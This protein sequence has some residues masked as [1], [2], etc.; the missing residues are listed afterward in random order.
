MALIL[1]T[2]CA[3][4]DSG[5]TVENDSVTKTSSKQETSSKSEASSDK[6]LATD[7]ELEADEEAGTDLEEGNNQTEDTDAGNEFGL[8]DIDVNVGDEVIESTPEEAL[9]FAKNMKAGWNLGNTL[10]AWNSG[11]HNQINSEVCWGNPKT[12]KEMMELLKE[13]GFSTVRI[14]VSWHNQSYPFLL[15]LQNTSVII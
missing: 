11:Q 15:T 9:E 7:A 12:T 13:S 2:G 1:L 8:E 6:E 3:T 5:K 4:A 14:P 10:D